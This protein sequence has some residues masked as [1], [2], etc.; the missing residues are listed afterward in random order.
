MHH[1]LVPLIIFIGIFAATSLTFAAPAT[2][3]STVTV[4]AAPKPEKAITLWPH[5]APGALGTAEKDTP[6]ITPF[7]A[8]TPAPSRVAF[9]VLP[10]GGYAMLADHEGATFAEWFA[11]HG[12]HA[13]VLRYRLGSEGYHYP[14]EFDDVS[15][16]L[17]YLRAHAADY[18]IDP[19]KI[20]IIGS[21]AGGH[22]ASTLLTHFDPGNPDAL[23]PIDR[24]S[25]R[26][27]LGVLCYPVIS[28][29]PLGHQGSLHN[30]LGEYPDP[31]LVALLSNEHQVKANTPPC[32]IWS[33]EDDPVVPVENSLLF[34]GA[35]REKKIPFDLH[36]YQH[37]PHGLGMQD[38]YPFAHP[39]PWVGDMEHWLVVNGWLK[40]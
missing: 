9:L 27:N 20:G 16:A 11:Q 2:D 15:R 28:M 37:G 5:G 22:L 7:L 3:Q 13:F 21:S 23:D 39:H 1:L 17:R 6:T 40:S 18:N 19:E 29:G 24:V 25:S 8:P 12:I 26:P 35:L 30:L 32:F 31:A 4:T 34:A 38:S 33:T 36:I 14:A 10:G